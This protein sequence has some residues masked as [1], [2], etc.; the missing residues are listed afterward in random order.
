M[1]SSGPV[2]R[3]PALSEDH[4]A[5]VHAGDIWLAKWPQPAGGKVQVDAYRL[6]SAK[7]EE[8]Y[9]RFSPDGKQIAFSANYDGNVDI[10]VLNIDGIEPPRRITHHPQSDRLLG[11]YPDGEHL[12]FASTLDAALLGFNRVYKVAAEGGLPESL[13][14]PFAE[15]ASVRPDGRAVAFQPTTRDF[16]GHSRW[17]GQRGGKSPDIWLFTPEKGLANGTGHRFKRLTESEANDA[18]P[19]WHPQ[20]QR[21]YFLSD[22]DGSRPCQTTVRYYNLWMQELDQC[23]DPVGQPAQLTHFTHFD[24]RH[25]DISADRILFENGGTLFLLDLQGSVSVEVA[26]SLRGDQPMRRPRTVSVGKTIAS[27]DIS[28]RGRRAVFEARGDIFTLP[29]QHGILRNLTRSNSAHRYPAWSPDGKRVAYWSDREGGSEPEYQLYLQ[30]ADG[31]GSPRQISH[32]FKGGYRYR[33][34]W[35]PC[36]QRLAFVDQALVLQYW[37]NKN[38]ELV[39]VDNELS[40][41]HHWHLERFSVSWSP[42]GRWLTYSRKVHP[43]HEAIFLFD[44]VKR[45]RIRLTSGFYNDFQ[46]TFDRGGRY[47]YFLTQRSFPRLESDLDPESDWVFSN[48]TQI[49]V[50][51]LD[52]KGSDTRAYSN[53]EEFQE[54]REEPSLGKEEWDFGDLS[55]DGEPSGKNS[56]AREFERRLQVLKCLEGN[57]E[58]L[59]GHFGKIF[60]IRTSNQGGPACRSDLQCYWVYEDDGEGG[61][62]FLHHEQLICED[63]ADFTLHPHCVG[64][65]ASE[66]ALR[67][68]VCDRQGSF[69]VLQVPAN[70]GQPIESWKLATEELEKEVDPVAEWRQI[71]HESWRMV[72]DYFPDPKTLENVKWDNLRSSYGRLLGRVS[73]R[74]DLDQLIADLLGNLGLSH[75]IRNGGDFETAELRGVGLLGAD[76]VV[77][78]DGRGK[79][80]VQ[81]RRILDGGAPHSELRSPLRMVGVV[82]G[83]YLIAINDIP[84]AE[85]P[86]PWKTLQGR[87]QRTVVLTVRNRLNDGEARTVVVKTLD[88]RQ[89]VRLR[90]LAWIEGN[91]KRVAEATKDQVGYVF[92]SNTTK[93]G[94]RE[95]F[96]QLQPQAHLKGLIIDNRFNFGG[97]YPDRL[98]EVLDRPYWAQ[99]R[100]RAGKVSRIPYLSPPPCQVMLINGW[101]GS[102]G[103]L[104]AYLFSETSARAKGERALVGSP[105]LGGLLGVSGTPTLIDGGA[106]SLPDQ[107]VLSPAGEWLIEGQ[108]VKPDLLEEADFARLAKGEDNQLEL[109]IKKIRELLDRGGTA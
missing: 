23:G 81:F 44:T 46:P 43:Q 26:V 48:S 69:S 74:W 38:R 72:R 15:F 56:F 99:I 87:D 63:A 109:A 86:N 59:Q 18:F 9:P 93:D 55:A 78:E 39:T 106:V 82:E 12:L 4:L 83:E 11:W 60:Y 40:W 6:T 21:I 79:P 67:L 25:P 1:M 102:S 51:T 37:D 30:V 100:H 95:F 7:G 62:T 2:L 70:P 77:E 58:R 61:I 96:R 10:Y 22:R 57:Y 41:M 29:R 24:V 98:I 14:I 84:L 32:S 49:A 33:L 89:E 94:Q 17:P 91:R 45:Q 31:S 19:V 64:V 101:T 47:L 27:C 66:V 92:L 73:S 105:T 103:E 36:S 28:P 3:Y 34:F 80:L 88:L 8:R 53:E 52:S 107:I 35:C 54:E 108:P 71:F 5:F 97:L 85:Y 75:F 20:G 16:I 13:S 90:Q 42:G 76:F 65:K 50:A 68:L 104:L